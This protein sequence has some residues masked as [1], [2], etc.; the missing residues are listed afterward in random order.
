MKPPEPLACKYCVDRICDKQ[1]EM[2]GK[3]HQ[4]SMSNITRYECLP[5]CPLLA[6]K[7]TTMKFDIEKLRAKGLSES[8]LRICQQINDN[9]TR[10]ESCKG[11]VFERLENQAFPHSHRCVKC[12]YEA[13][14]SYVLGYQDAIAHMETAQEGLKAIQQPNDRPL[15]Y[16]KLH[17]RNEYFPVIRIEWDSVQVQVMERISPCVINTV[18]FGFIDE[19]KAISEIETEK[20]HSDC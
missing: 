15:A 10:K 2:D 8:S 18:S 19:W 14:I 17:G 4:V 12:G 6:Q 11:H 5:E 9:N 3:P 16:V 20:H 1:Q 7:A 13:D